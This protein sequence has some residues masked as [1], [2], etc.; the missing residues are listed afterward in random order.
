MSVL[1]D[2]TIAFL[3]GGNMAAALIEGLIA[4]NAACQILVCDRNEDKLRAFEA[5]GASVYLPKDA[6]AMVELADVVVLAV[7]PQQLL[8]ACQSLDLQ[9]K[10][11]VSVA[12]GVSIASIEQMTGASRVVRVMPNLPA[13]VGCGAAGLYAHL[14]D[15]DKA[16]AEAILAASGLCVWVAKE[17]DLHTVTAVAGSAPA[18]FF[19]VLEA[20]IEQAQEMGLSAKDAHSLAV[21]TM[22]G[23]AKMAQNC[24]PK[25]LRAQVTSKGGTTHAAICALDSQN[26][27]QHFKDAMQACADRSRELGAV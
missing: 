23:A 12:A 4:T 26:S 11:L 10:L 13:T 8:Q 22:L 18:Y 25:T 7:K 27:A 20:M 3:G 5:K 17:E 6:H 19:Y 14:G 16:L 9:D 15:E 21:Q 24:D 2:K 1:T